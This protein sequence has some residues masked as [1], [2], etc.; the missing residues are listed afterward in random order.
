[1]R[2]LVSEL[3]SL[4]ILKYGIVA[5]DLTPIKAYFKPS[6]EK[7]T[8]ARDPD[9]AWGYSKSKNGWYY[10]YKAHIIVNIETQIPIECIV[11]PANISDQKMMRPFIWKLKKQGILL[12]Y[13]LLDK[14]YDSEN[15][16]FDIREIF[17]SIGLIAPNMRKKKKKNNTKKR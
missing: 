16:H 2:A 5:L 8:K 13:T 4:N 15:N 9:A 7:N 3:R 11:T 14:G 10:G 1:M 12:K 6:T 17:G